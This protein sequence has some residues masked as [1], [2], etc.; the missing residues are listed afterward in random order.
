MGAHPWLPVMKS[1][2]ITPLV[3]NF[4]VKPLYAETLQKSILNFL[5]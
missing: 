1:Y 4:F 2:T 3:S 5:F